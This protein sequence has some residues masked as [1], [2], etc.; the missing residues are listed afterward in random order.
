MFR[1]YIKEYRKITEWEWY[2]DYKTAHLFRHCLYKANLENKTWRGQE[3]LRGSF[4]TSRD[5]LAFETGLTVQEVR[6]ALKKLKL[7][8]E[9]TSVSTSQY[10]I[11]T[12]VNW[13]MY[14]ANQPTNQPTIN[15]HSNQQITTTKEIKEIKKYRE[16]DRKILENYLLNKKRAK[17][18]DNIDA[19]I[20][21]IQPDSLER[22]IKKAYQWQAKQEE[23]KQ[24][25]EV[26]NEIIEITPEEE[27]KIKEIQEQIK[28]RRRLQK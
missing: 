23:K 18:I 8:N 27:K 3:I 2:K 22:L 28:K 5:N 24:E 16:R 6:T 20:D 19:Y 10:T 14:Q 25:R 13:D 26:K 11:I 7:T 21:N 12:V 1:G 4:I 9:L 17:P 15:Q